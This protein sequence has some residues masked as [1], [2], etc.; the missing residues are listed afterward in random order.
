[1]AYVNYNY[2]YKI[3]SLN[4]G[5]IMVQET[6]YIEKRVR[7]LRML[8]QLL[9]NELPK[10]VTPYF[11]HMSNKTNALSGTRLAYAEDLR[12]YFHFLKERSP[13]CSGLQIKDIP[14]E[15]LDR[16][17]PEDIDEY[18]NYLECYSI[19]GRTYSNSF[20]G[21]AR[22]LAS[23]RSFYYY[24]YSRKK[25]SSD[26]TAI[27]ESI[28]IP[29]KEIIILN[30]EQKALLYSA[31]N[32]GNVFRANER[33]WKFYLKTRLRDMAIFTLLLGTAMRIS[34]LVGINIG[35]IDF[36]EQSI[37]ITRKGNKMSTVYYGEESRIALE[38]Y[39]NPSDAECA[40][41]FLGRSALLG[42]E[43]ETDALFLSLKNRRITPRSV[44]VRFH[45]YT[46]PLF[47][48]KNN[49]TPHK[50][51]ST[52]GSQIYNET[53]DIYLVAD[54]LGHSSVETTRKHYS[55]IDVERKKKLTQSIDVF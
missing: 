23:L 21:K 29:D 10:Y 30:S 50:M 37:R 39:L 20:S 36:N 12:I 27:I 33:K 22:K 43:A 31:V 3:I 28:R 55:K 46:D 42:S 48:A 18:L 15:V 54:V 52:R 51:R 9:K 34:E 2:L 4:E 11:N 19:G 14:L 6:Y 13:L 49:F 44:Q 38:A 17:T 35:D 16:Q 26:P 5:D 1:M 32:T 8:E 53:G 40:A 41:G 45:E 7:D 25:V 47:G 24:L